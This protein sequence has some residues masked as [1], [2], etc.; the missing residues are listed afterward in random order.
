MFEV[1]ARAAGPEPTWGQRGARGALSLRVTLS[2]VGGLTCLDAAAGSI[3]GPFWPQPATSNPASIMA[4][5]A[6]RAL[7]EGLRPKISSARLFFICEL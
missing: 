2:G 6:P 1:L 7:L 4:A 5:T 3:S